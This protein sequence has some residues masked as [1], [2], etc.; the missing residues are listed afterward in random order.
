MWLPY[1]KV[2]DI[3]VRSCSIMDRPTTLRWESLKEKGHSEDRG[4]DGTMG[5]QW[6]L[7]RLDVGGGG[8]GVDSNDSA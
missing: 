1:L 5:S 8:D 3:F 2:F 7:G 6:I 4:V